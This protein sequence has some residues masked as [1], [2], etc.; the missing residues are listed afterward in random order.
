MA[1][2]LSRNS[3]RDRDTQVDNVQSESPCLGH[4]VL[5]GVSPSNPFCAQGK[6][7][8]SR[9]R[10]ILKTCLNSHGNSEDIFQKLVLPQLLNVGTK[11]KSGSPIN[12]K[13]YINERVGTPK[14]YLTTSLPP[15]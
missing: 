5:N 10:N 11:L 15:H 3:R 1:Y 2:P 4:S 9:G 13:F 6:L 7:C 12:K 14:S 8:I